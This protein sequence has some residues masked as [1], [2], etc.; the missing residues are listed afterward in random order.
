MLEATHHIEMCQD[1]L[2]IGPTDD[3]SHELL[4][5]IATWMRDPEGVTKA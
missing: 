5:A 1:D 2:L 4:E 3:P